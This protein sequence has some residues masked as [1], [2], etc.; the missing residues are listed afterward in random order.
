MIK[1]DITDY[2]QSKGYTLRECNRPA[3]ITL[4]KAQSLG[5]DT[6]DEYLEALHDFINGQ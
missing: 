1:S 3:V 5:Y 2:I 4:E 6:V